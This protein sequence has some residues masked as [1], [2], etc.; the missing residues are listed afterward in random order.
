MGQVIFCR[1]RPLELDN[2][3]YRSPPPQVGWF[4]RLFPSLSFHFQFLWVVLAASRLAKRGLYDH[5]AWQD[6]SAQIVRALESVGVQLEVTGLNHVRAV[7][8][9]CLV[10]GNHAST[11][12]TV[13]LP[14]LLRDLSPITFVVFARLLEV[15]IFKHVMRSRD[16]IAVRQVSV[17]DDFKA[18]LT[19][20]SERIERGVSLIIFPEGDRIAEF[21]RA[22]FNTIGA[23]LA[24]RTSAPVIPMAVRTDAWPMGGLMSYIGRI[25]PSRPVRIAFGPPIES[26]DRGTATQAALLEFIESNLSDWRHL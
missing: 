7:R 24:A 17:R 11:L 20:G 3:E 14:V 16:P 6:S 19:G 21:D 13:V 15:P 12:E 5:K 4:S 25:Y 22:N 8:K 9:P 23:K 26:D 10:V 18:M 2:D 1:V